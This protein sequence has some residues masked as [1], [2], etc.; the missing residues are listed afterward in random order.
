MYIAGH[1]VVISY[2]KGFVCAPTCKQV[3]KRACKRSLLKCFVSSHASI[4][5]YNILVHMCIC[6]YT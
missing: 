6:F 3:F 5:T 2:V 1:Q 4:A